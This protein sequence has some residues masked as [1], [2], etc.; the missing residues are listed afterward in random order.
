MGPDGAGKTT[1][2]RLL[3]KEL[4]RLGVQSKYVWMRFNH[5]LSLPILAL[6]RLLKLSKVE[7]LR[8]GKKVVYH[9]FDKL[10]AVALIYSYTLFIDTLLSSY[11]KVYLRMKMGTFVICDRFAYDTLVDLM[12]STRN[13]KFLNSFVAKLF[14]SLASRATA[15]TLIGS[16]DTLRARRK[17][18]LEDKD[19][20]LKVD[21]YS[22]LSF[23]YRIPIIDADKPIAHV[24]HEIMQT[25]NGIINET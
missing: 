16:P 22:L 5:R 12:V 4:N 25:V 24:H 14:L 21:F 19:L 18:L 2:A 11:F 20:E 15:I 3:E 7:R 6:A 10:N 8:C 17:D 9:H 23:R 13:S 1:Q